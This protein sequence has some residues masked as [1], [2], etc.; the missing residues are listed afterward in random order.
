VI[1][2]EKCCYI[3]GVI[4]KPAKLAATGAPAEP[5][6]TTKFSGV[7]CKK[8]GKWGGKGNYTTTRRAIVCNGEWNM[9]QKYSSS[10]FSPRN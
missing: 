5:A 3:E 2:R 4:K 8:D 1:P 9:T 6:E 7:L 10:N